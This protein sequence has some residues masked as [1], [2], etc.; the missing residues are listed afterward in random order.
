M[1]KKAYFILQSEDVRK[2]TDSQIKKDF[3]DYKIMVCNGA[4]NSELLLKVKAN[5]KDVIL[6]AYENMMDA[7][8]IT[9]NEP[10]YV[11]KA[12]I[13]RPY[14]QDICLFRD[15]QYYRL[16]ASLVQDLV[17]FH[18]EETLDK[19]FSGVY[20]DICSRTMPPHRAK[21]LQE[22][23]SDIEIEIIKEEY[24]LNRAYYTALMRNRDM[25]GVYVGNTPA[26]L[27]DPCL[28]GVGFEGLGGMNSSLISLAVLTG[29][30]DV[31][32]RIGGPYNIAWKTV[33]SDHDLIDSFSK[34]IPWLYAGDMNTLK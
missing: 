29:Q 2:R 26:W 7:T 14:L 22:I 33:N 5:V 34:S 17:D 13:M 23:Y 1:V 11:K 4:I 19:G 20:F 6:L 16:D 15:T 31:A 25:D 24:A 8:A 18:C 30:A 27:N 10:Y 32:W 21:K 28:N 3:K 12:E 9:S